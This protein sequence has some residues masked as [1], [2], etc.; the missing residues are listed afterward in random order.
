MCHRGLKSSEKFGNICIDYAPTC[1]CFFIREM[2]E[3]RDVVTVHF[4][5]ESQYPGRY[6]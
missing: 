1:V 6:R 3:T 4:H 5:P 2:Y